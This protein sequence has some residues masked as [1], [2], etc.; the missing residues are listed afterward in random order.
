M[1][2]MKEKGLIRRIGSDRGG[3]WEVFEGLRR[4][5]WGKGL[6]FLNIMQNQGV[7]LYIFPHIYPFAQP[8]TKSQP[9][10]LVFCFWIV[11]LELN[12]R[13]SRFTRMK[14]GRSTPVSKSEWGR[15]TQ[16]QARQSCS[17]N[18][19]QK[20]TVTL[21]VTVFFCNELLDS[22]IKQLIFF[23]W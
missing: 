7:I 3:Y 10:W 12:L 17:C 11:W 13:K 9:L 1:R 2:Q 16:P 8:K 15:G 4:R 14:G 21:C 23:V 5:I 22:V 6:I 19:L 18:S 20:N